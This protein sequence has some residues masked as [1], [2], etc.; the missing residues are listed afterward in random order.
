MYRKEILSN[1]FRVVTHDIAQRDSVAIGFWLGVGGRYEANAEK[2]IAHVIEHMLFKGSQKYSC[3]AI[4]ELIEGVGGTLNAF[5]AEEQTCFYAKIP[6][7]YLDRTFDVLADMVFFPKVQPADLVKEKTVIIEEIKMYHDLPQHVV[8]EKLDQ[9]MWPDHPLGESLAGSAETVSKVTS[10]DIKKFHGVHYNPCNAVLAVCGDLKHRHIVELVEKKLGQL[11]QLAKSQYVKVPSAL[12]LPKTIYTKKDIEQM[13]LAL[14]MRAY[15]ENHKDKHVV[16]LLA[17]ILGGN[18]S[19][20]LF[21]EVRE[22]KGLAYS[23]GT[24][25]RC[26]HDTGVFMVRAGVDNH[27]IVEALGLIL[28]ELEKIRTKGVLAGEF[29]RAK[30]YLLGQLLLG[31]EDTMDHMLWL[32]ESVVARDRL[33]TLKMIVHEFEKIKKEDV[34]RVAKEILCKDRFNLSIVGPVQAKDEKA[35]NRLLHVK[36]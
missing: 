26:F 18:M 20:R 1:G 4:K 17:T 6:S 29:T 2:G 16:T 11:K 3:S 22:K 25:A 33:K 13:H 19:S 12:E 35:M 31:M 21:V 30:D 15:D 10:E 34:R 28:K 36:A 32:G 27:K 7:K 9:L 23:I 14:G 24:S 8:L 5:T